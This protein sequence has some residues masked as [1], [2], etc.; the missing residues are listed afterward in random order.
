MVPPPIPP[1]GTP[2][3]YQISNQNKCY[4]KILILEI[5]KV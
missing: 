2:G 3:K 5:N 1:K 4:N